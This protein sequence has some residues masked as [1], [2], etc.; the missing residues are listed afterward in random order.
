MKKI[1]IATLLVLLAACQAQT[2]PQGEQASPQEGATAS[3]RV[4]ATVDPVK[5]P[6]PVLTVLDQDGK[7]VDLGA[8]YKQGIVLVYFYPKADTPGCTAQACSLRDSYEE[9]TSKG[10]KVIGVSLDDAQS[11][12][13]F[14]KK[15]DLP[16]TLI[17]DTDK[18]M[19]E[20]F[21]VSHVGGFASRQAFLI[22]DGIIEWHDGSASTS[23][24]AEDVLTQLESWA[25]P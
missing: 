2:T 23:K 12:K 8:L 15:Y 5:K 6:A 1:A 22:K 11:Q 24:Q 25:K 20:A 13:D 19:V 4:S 18:T 14:Q 17:P 9:L 7:S 3:P 16:F 21:G 10:V